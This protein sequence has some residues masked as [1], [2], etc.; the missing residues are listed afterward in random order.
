LSRAVTVVRATDIHTSGVT[1]AERGDNKLGAQHVTTAPPKKRL[2]NRQ[3]RT[4]S[5][6][7]C[8]GGLEDRKR[9]LRLAQWKRMEN[10]HLYVPVLVIGKEN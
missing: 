4:T 3:E 10:V 5:P 7:T 2:P 9:E 8:A 6:R 1:G